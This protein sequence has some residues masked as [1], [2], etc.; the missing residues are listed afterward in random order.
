MEGHAEKCFE[1]CC[2]LAKKTVSSLLQVATP[3]MDDNLQPLGNYETSA[4]LCAL[5]AQIVPKCCFLERN[6]RPDSL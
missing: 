5:C 3:C 2:E 4:E 1:R 6:G